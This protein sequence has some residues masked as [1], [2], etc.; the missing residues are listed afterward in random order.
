MAI[1]PQST[2][3][4]AALGADLTVPCPACGKRYRWRDELAGKK[5]R[6][7]GCGG[8]FAPSPEATESA[9]AHLAEV[10]AAAAR[11]GFVVTDRRSPREMSAEMEE[12]TRFHNWILP[13]IVL[14]PVLLWR[15]IQA[16]GH[17]GAREDVSQGIALFLVLMEAVLVAGAILGSLV[18]VA[19]VV[20]LEVTDWRSAVLKALASA[21]AI[22]ALCTF[23]AQFDFTTWDLNS[24]ML[25]VP[26]ILLIAYFMY[27]AMYR[28][29]LLEGLLA[30]VVTTVLVTVVLLALA[31]VVR[32]PAGAILAFGR[33]SV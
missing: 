2:R 16:T 28:A 14:A 20:E 31:N 7:K 23:F 33:P 24:M 8:V 19:S 32:G 4:G 25:G 11:H 21:F 17:A 5:I 12:T 22:T 9:Q 29:D 6:C 26:S 27:T 18:A 15:V 3:T 13:V 10:S 30:T 1:A